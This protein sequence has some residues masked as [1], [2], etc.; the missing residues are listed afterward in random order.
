MIALLLVPGLAGC[1]V[2]PDRFEVTVV[3]QK[4][5]ERVQLFLCDQYRADLPFNSGR[6]MLIRDVDCEG[7]GKV[8]VTFTRNTFIDCPLGYVTPNAGQIWRF[9]ATRVRCDSLKVSS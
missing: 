5:P 8:R 2:N 9:K 7:S 6:Y 3:D 4:R 1:A